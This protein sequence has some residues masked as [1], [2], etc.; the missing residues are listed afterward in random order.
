MHSVTPIAEGLID[1]AGRAG[2]AV[3][4]RCVPAD[5][6]I[7]ASSSASHWTTIKPGARTSPLQPVHV[8]QRSN[9]HAAHMIRF[10]ADELPALPFIK[11]HPRR[12]PFDHHHIH[13]RLP[14]P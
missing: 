10:G 5:R 1:E 9:I 3:L 7:D 2:G 12:A 6:V 14:L 4:R 13:L 8:A 11:A